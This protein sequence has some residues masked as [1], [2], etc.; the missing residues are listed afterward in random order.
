MTRKRRTN[1]ANQTNVD[2][3]MRRQNKKRN[4][5]NSQL[6]LNIEPMTK[7]QVSLF[8]SYSEGKNIIAYGSAG[9]G[10]AQPIYSKILTP[11]GWVT[12]G[13]ISIGDDIIT[14]DG[15][16]SKVLNVYPQG[17]KDIYEIT[18]HDGSKTR[19]CK[20]HL[21]ECY[22]PN[23]WNYRK[24]STKKI[25]TTETLFDFI[26]YKNTN[27]IKQNVN[28]SIDLITP[29]ETCD[30][31]LPLNPYLLGVLIG[32]GCIT[33]N[34]P[35]ITNS[36]EE[37]LNGI[38]N[39]LKEEHIG[40]NLNKIKSAKYDYFIVDNEKRFNIKGSR[41]SNRITKL[42]KQLNLHGKKSYEKSIPAVYMNSSISQKLELI[43]GLFDT[44]GTVGTKQK[45]G[46]VTYTS[47]SYELIQQV[48]ELI[49]SIGGLATIKKRITN[50]T[51][52]NI[53]K[54]G[55][56]SY[57]LHVK[58]R[59]NKNLFS[60]TEKKDRCKD[61]F[62]K[63]QYRRKIIDVSYI[64]KEEA[65]CIL[66]DD[67]NH[68]Y[69]TDDYIITHNT[70]CVLY[71]ALREV[72]DEKS[73]YEKIYIIRSIVSTR[74]VGFL[75]GMLEE[76]IEMY[77]MP[78]KYMVKFMFQLASDEDFSM[79]YGNLKSQKTIEFSST[80]FI[81]GTTYDNCIII[82]DEFSNLNFHELDSII[83]RVGEN[84]KICFCGDAEQSDLVKTS[85]RNGI[86]DFMDILR[87]MPSFDIIEFG[88]EDV[89]RSGLVKEYLTVK[90]ELGI[91]SI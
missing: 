31:E 26:K 90:H 57:T 61:T 15:Y 39:I 46:G 29:K 27:L 56:A 19:A 65:K 14:P 54:Q 76:K 87:K 21:W 84:S 72:L 8:D 33:Q 30:I 1:D 23:N 35:I 86:I 9:T 91:S 3:L 43:R 16:T 22:Y 13:N 79:L 4:P 10:K 44:D 77:E 63:L 11:S 49:W 71:N 48:Q 47:T 5:I 68:L 28:I 85:E 51:Y 89:I 52:N 67:P 40:C 55:R 37:L 34:T 50:Y 59:N 80:S 62:D 82:V 7:T 83:T 20:E 24:G 42:L 25:V 70:F 60:I 53:K 66:I 81:R 64:G 38:R 36:N 58:T 74:D 73:P 78:Y 18:F 41:T 88:I 69:I 6:L 2:G 45:H 32:D 75:P 17:E 12:M